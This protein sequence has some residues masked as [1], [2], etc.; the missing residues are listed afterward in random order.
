MTLPNTELPVSPYATYVAWKQWDR[1]FAYT[2]EQARYFAGEMRG[3]AVAGADLLEIGYGSGDFLAWARD[4][5]ARVSGVEIIPAL[6]EAARERGI[7]LLP[8]DLESAA[9]HH[10]AAFDTIIAFDVFEHLTPDVVAMRLVTCA[11]MLKPGGHLVLRF[12]NGQSPFGLVPQGGDPTHRS[13]L[14]RGA[15]EQLMLSTDLVVVRYAPSFRITG[16]GLLKG[17]ARRLRYLAR[18]MISVTLNAIY[19]ESIPWDAVVVIALRK[20]HCRE[21]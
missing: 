10:A 14:S 18:D 4:K 3:L 15:I 1:L 21:P 17:L 12:P 13:L 5:G 19:A 6:V 8:P 2:P 9:A 20:G 11:G 7:P 16:G